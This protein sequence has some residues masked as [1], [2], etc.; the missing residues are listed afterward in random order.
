MSVQC[1]ILAGMTGY[2][3]GRLS[4][5][6]IPIFEV[7]F[8]T[9]TEKS[10]VVRPDGATSCLLLLSLVFF[11]SDSTGQPENT[12]SCI[13]TKIRSEKAKTK[14]KKDNHVMNLNCLKKFWVAYRL[15]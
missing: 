2:E 1:K 5:Y 9:L 14:K 15:F 6:E 7:I 11:L 10:S 4:V 8:M 13:L 3:K 12:Y